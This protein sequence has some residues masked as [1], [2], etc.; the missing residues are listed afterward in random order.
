[1]L[2]RFHMS[3]ATDIVLTGGSSGGLA[4]YLTC[5]LVAD[6]VAAA[7]A[8]AVKAVVGSA[9]GS[10][11]TAPGGA[12]ATARLRAAPSFACLADAG[13]FL[14]HP[15]KSGAPSTSPLFEESFYAWNSRS[16][17]VL[18]RLLMYP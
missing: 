15:D 6:Q 4:T 8:T 9:V 12:A 5:D 2:A 10:A 11:A 7:H 13:Y 17:T 16:A 18:R 14:D 3:S 1:M